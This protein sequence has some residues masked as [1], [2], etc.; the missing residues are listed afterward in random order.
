MP[1]F[2]MVPFA[3]KNRAQ[4]LGAKWN[5]GVKQWYIPDELQSEG[6]VSRVTELTT[7]YDYAYLAVPF[8]QK[9]RA[10]ALGAKWD[11]NA[12]KWYTLLANPN[13]PK[14]EEYLEKATKLEDF[15]FEDYDLELPHLSISDTNLLQEQMDYK[16]YLQ[17][18][19]Y[20]RTRSEG[21]CQLCLDSGLTKNELFLCEVY[22][23]IPEEETKKLIR[24]F[25]ACKDCRNLY[26]YG[27]KNKNT[28]YLMK[29]TDMNEEEATKLIQ[30]TVDKKL[31]LDQ[32]KWT[33]DLSIITDNGLKLKQ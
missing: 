11:A 13:F 30:D 33:L 32:I 6:D 19:E 17:L 25:S 3:D 15:D 18:D 21:E 20:V 31:E 5:A 2:L 14:L 4:N 10:K 12:K 9:D 1:K 8:A 7:L 16:D 24:L 27:I 29:L 23:Y 26:K 28:S 22:E